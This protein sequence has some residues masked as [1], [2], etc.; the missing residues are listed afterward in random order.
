MLSRIRDVIQVIR[1]LSSPR[2]PWRLFALERYISYYYVVTN[3]HPIFYNA[4]QRAEKAIQC[5]TWHTTAP[6]HPASCK[7]SRCVK[8][9][10]KY[11]KRI[12]GGGGRRS[13]RV[14]FNPSKW[15]YDQV[16]NE[17]QGS[18]LHW[19]ASLEPKVYQDLWTKY[20][21]GRIEMPNNK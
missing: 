19:S 16:H 9:R 2:P 3:H 20:R 10:T 18:P 6:T 12:K 15:I 13:R 11:C 5:H 21:I 7:Q 17:I 14:S 1:R 4:M 8:E